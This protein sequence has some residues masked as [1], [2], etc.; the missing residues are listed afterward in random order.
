MKCVPLAPKI[1]Y[2]SPGRSMLRIQKKVT[3]FVLFLA[4][5]VLQARTG[6]ITALRDAQG[7]CVYVNSNDKELRA[8]LK[9]GGVAAA[10]QVIDQRKRALPGIDQFIDQTAL[11]QRLDP[12]LV[13][14]IIQVESAWN[15]R[16]R[17]RKGALGLMQ[18]MPE[19]ALRFGVHDAFNAREN[20]T[21]G[22]RYLRFLLDR[23][24]ENLKYT[25][26]AYNAGEKAVAAWGDVPPYEETRAY[27]D[28]I[29]MIY[30]AQRQETGLSESAISRT[31]KGNRVIY[32]NLD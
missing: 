31:V 29:G 17:S 1:R 25:L 26:A 14:A 7:R 22:T 3:L 15:D 23:F 4:V 11:Q 10:L 19:T 27:L 24:H 9:S 5:P 32:T 13:R 21:G 18:L 6:E 8:S 16:A 28:R 2:V 30:A 20:I 12:R